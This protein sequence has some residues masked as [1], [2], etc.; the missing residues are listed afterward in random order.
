[1]IIPNPFNSVGPVLDPSLFFNRKVMIETLLNNL[2]S[3]KPACLSIVGQ[4]KIGKTSLA[5]HL[6]RISTMEKFGFDGSRYIFLNFNCQRVPRALKDYENFNTTLLGNILSSL[7]PSVSELSNELSRL[8]PSWDT[9][10]L[11]DRLLAGLWDKGFYLIVVF[12][13][14]DKAIMQ[15]SLIKGGLFGSLRG[16]ANDSPNFS[17]VT[18]TSRPLHVIFEDAFNEFQISNSIRIAESDFFNIASPVVIKLFNSDET[19]QMV[20]TLA[21]L[22]NIIFS[23]ETLRAIVNCGGNFPFFTQRAGYHFSKSFLSSA[24]DQGSAVQDFIRESIPIWDG[25]WNKLDSR[26]QVLLSTIASENSTN[27]SDYEINNLIDSSLVYEDRSGNL[28]PFSSEFGRFVLSKKVISNHIFTRGDTLYDRYRVVNVKATEHSQIAKAWDDRLKRFVAIKTPRIDLFETDEKAINKLKKNLRREAELLA[29]LHH[30][31]IGQVF[32]MLEEPIG[33][34]MEWVDGQPLQDI[35]DSRE[36]LQVDDILIMGLGIADAL[37]YAHKEGVIHRDIKP[38]NIILMNNNISKLIDFD[39]ARDEFL[40]TITMREDGTRFQVG[41]PPYSS[42]EQL[43]KPDEDFFND[44]GPAS[45]IFSLGIVLYE[46]LV[47]E[48]PYKYGNRLSQ[49]GDS[50]PRLEQY[51]IPTPFYEILCKMLDGKNSNRPS[52]EALQRE[53]RE[54]SLHFRNSA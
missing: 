22:G 2:L 32:D 20:N 21:T 53:L 36:K 7:P 18:I 33:I 51:D 11:W 42:P 43:I 14:F 44:I 28:R 46:L 23:E 5:L 3:I 29:K 25:F 48:R 26:Q 10:Q 19:H 54:C 4:R 6:A 41:T 37:A 50:F 45:D 49:Y 27:V 15:E 24:P 12:D 34:V 38:N 40:E 1:M 52:A 39:V 30:Q 35:L 8:L 9:A 31:N 47:F 13:E 17:W 16:Y